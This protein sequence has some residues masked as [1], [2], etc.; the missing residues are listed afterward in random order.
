MIKGIKEDHETRIRQDDQA[1]TCAMYVGRVKAGRG[2]QW[3]F[4]V[5]HIAD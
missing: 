4:Y 1:L 3:A 5:Y 2:V